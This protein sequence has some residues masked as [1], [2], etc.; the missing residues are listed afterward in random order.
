M[1]IFLSAAGGAGR[2]PRWTDDRESDQQTLERMA[3]GDA[4]AL[5]DLYDRHAARVYSLALRIVRDAGDAEDVV[6]E[7]F[8]QAWRQASRYTAS[9]GAV[10]AWLLTLARSRAIDR[11]RARRARPDQ[12]GAEAAATELPDLAPPVDWQYLSAEQIR[13]VRAA[14]EQLPFLQRV[15]IEL[16]YFDGLTHVE[17]AARLEEPLGTVKTRIRSA[18]TK[19]RESLV[20]A[21]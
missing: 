2:L 18:L 17:I 10:A 9:R 13:L 14:L 7:V 5:A 21:V 8:A 19:L 11:L 16:A 12:Q 6:Q 20:G 4:D 1:W 3:R 15:A